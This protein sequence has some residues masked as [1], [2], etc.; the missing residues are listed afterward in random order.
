MPGHRLEHWEYCLRKQWSSMESNSYAGAGPWT[1]R[2]HGRLPSV[3]APSLVGGPMIVQV[4]FARPED[5]LH[6][7]HHSGVTTR[8]LTRN[9]SLKRICSL[10]S[11]PRKQVRSRSTRAAHELS[12]GSVP[13][14]STLPVREHAA[15]YP[16]QWIRCRRSRR[17]SFEENCH[18]LVV[19]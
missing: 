10:F 15:H 9:G 6:S 2:M 3:R 19:R 11:C 5:G 18:Y 4:S 12:P 13:M 16:V 14:S 8:L 7:A 1:K 17:T